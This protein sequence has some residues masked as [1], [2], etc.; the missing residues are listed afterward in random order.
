MTAQSSDE[1]FI[2][3]TEEV[4]RLNATLDVLIAQVNALYALFALK[5]VHDGSGWH[6]IPKAF[7][8]E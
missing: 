4:K 1:R 7:V 2:D 3:L 5:A 6:A 8:E